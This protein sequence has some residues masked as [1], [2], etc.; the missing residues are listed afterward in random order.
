MKPLP[1]KIDDFLIEKIEEEARRKK[2]TKAEVVRTALI[3]YLLDRQDLLDAEL[4][5]SRLNEPDIP[6]H[7]VKFSS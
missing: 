3:Y 7:S 5:K 2:Q 6:E 4:I 1:L